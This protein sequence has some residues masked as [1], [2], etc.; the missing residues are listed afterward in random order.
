MMSLSETTIRIL[1]AEDDEDDVLIVQELL[2]EG[3]CDRKIELDSVTNAEDIF[4]TLEEKDYDLCFVDFRL[5][6]GDGL[7]ILKKIRERFPRVSVMMLTGQGDQQIAVEAMKLGALDY[8][9]KGRLELQTFSHAVRRAIRLHE[10]GRHRE[11]MEQAL[12]HQ[13]DLVRA[14]S[15]A[16]SCLLMHT[17]SMAA[18]RRSL[19]IMFPALDVEWGGLYLHGSHPGNGSTGWYLAHQWAHENTGESFP[20]GGPRA[21]ST[22]EQPVFKK[23]VQQLQKTREPI[24]LETSR[25][26][27]WE[28]PLAIP[29][30]VQDSFFGFL[31]L[32]RDRQAGAWED[33]HQSLLATFAASLGWEL[34]R[35]REE[36]AFR[37]LIQGTSG[38]TGEEFFEAL[39]Q[40]LTHALGFRYAFVYE[41]VEY[42]NT[43]ARVVKGWNG[44]LVHGG[45]PFDLVGSPGEEVLGGMYCYY[46]N[47]VREI[48]PGDSFLARFK[49][50]S[51]AAVPFFDSAGKVSGFLAVLDDRP[52]TDRE[53]VL[54]I[55]RLFA[56][57][58]GA[59][60]ERQKNEERIRN[61]AYHDALTGLPNRILLNDRL[62]VAL[63]QAQRNKTMVAVLFLDFDNFKEV[64]DS[65]GHPVGDQL[66]KEGAQRL[67]QCL[68]EG[69]TVARLGG[70]EFVLLLPGLKEVGD[71][72]RV[73]LK[74]NSV[75][76]NPF[77]IEDHEIRVSV[78]LGISVFPLD[79]SDS[80]TLLKRAD[81]ALFEA[82]KK[83]RDNFQFASPVAS[84]GNP[85]T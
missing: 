60:I 10:E 82:K 42:G 80:K 7:E 5:G 13:G 45:E 49:V 17:D 41:V 23:L 27:P 40:H 71:A 83:G 14:L 2:K 15:E 57:R 44:M 84:P 36:K 31:V 75:M 85:K 65:L 35:D 56:A 3:L 69:D 19:E 11:R 70:D 48:F 34:K 4:R 16:V 18:I 73:A 54:S 77:Y 21:E 12:K 68:R 26:F 72:S 53:R 46:A 64:N 33:S 47:R 43:L 32:G 52:M 62:G 61:M 74:V 51:Y 63:R 9:D 67:T 29:I 37:S 66:L 22:P 8:V 25:L 20:G 50:N 58:A 55:L 79:G 30:H 38:Q 6:A 28:F 24:P 59:E 81:D 1:M 76:K 39:V 78:S